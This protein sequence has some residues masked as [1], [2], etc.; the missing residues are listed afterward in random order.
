VPPENVEIIQQNYLEGIPPLLARAMRAKDNAPA[1]PQKM[2]LDELPKEFNDAVMRPREKCIKPGKRP[3]QMTEEEMNEW[4]ISV[5]LPPRPLT[6]PEPEPAP[7][8][9]PAPAAKPAPEFRLIGEA[10]HSYVF[11]EVADRVMVVDK[12]A[13]HERILF[14]ELRAG[15]RARMASSDVPSQMMLVPYEV[16]L[17]PEEMSAIDNYADEVRALGFEFTRRD[18]HTLSVTA[19]PPI[20][21]ASAI[22]DVLITIADNVRQGFGTPTTVQSEIF[23]RALYQ[24]SCKAAIKGGRIEEPEHIKW[25]VSKLLSLDDIKVCPHG[26]PVAFDLTKSAIERQFKRV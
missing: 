21:E 16:P 9:A 1:K 18:D 15:M 19:I 3:S 5:G 13:A 10:F 14:E 23:E 6:K 8:P 22:A 4:R 7:D 11:V 12:H 24:A 26:R 17:T 20:L 25:I 2:V